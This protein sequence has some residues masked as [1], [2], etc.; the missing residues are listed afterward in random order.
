IS[1]ILDSYHFHLTTL[2]SRHS[3]FW[4]HPVTLR[5]AYHTF[6]IWGGNAWVAS[7]LESLLKDQ[8]KPVYATII[9]ME[10]RETVMPSSIEPNAIDVLNCAGGIGRPNVDSYED[11]KAITIHACEQ[12]G[13]HIST[14]D[15]TY[16]TGRPSFE[17][18]D[19][20]NSST[21]FYSATKS[22]VEE[23]R[24]VIEI[25]FYALKVAIS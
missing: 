11:N 18:T 9:R 24:K 3:P 8:G 16:P 6:L 25:G 2:S 19:T 15:E 10:N 7:Y 17:E 20:T 14:S 22:K 5:T 1:T 21:S 23:V 13:I 12:R 4:L